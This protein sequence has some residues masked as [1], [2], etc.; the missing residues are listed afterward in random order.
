[1]RP[2]KELQDSS[3]VRRD[4]QSYLCWRKNPWVYCLFYTVLVILFGAV[5][6]IT[7]SG[8]GCGQHWPSCKGDI[9][10]LP[11]SVETVIE[12]T[13]RVTSLTSMLL[14]WGLAIWTYRSG[15]FSLATR[16]SALGASFGMLLEALV[17]AAL[18]LLALVGENDSVYRAVIMGAHLCATS[19][20]LYF[21]VLLVLRTTPLASLKPPLQIKTSIRF[22]GRGGMALLLLISAAGAVTAL[23]DTLYP[24]SETGSGLGL[25][26]GKSQGQHFLESLRAF[27]PV[28][29][30][31]GAFFL[32]WGG[33]RFGA[34]KSLSLG[35]RLLL[36]AQLVA[37]FS[38]IALNA[39]GW[40]QVVH[41]LLAN[42]IWMLWVALY[43]RSGQV[44]SAVKTTA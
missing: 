6:R 11:Q 36:G 8:A 37:G 32:Y 34:D 29:A 28:L 7:G 9:V 20:L 44:P 25:L 31:V 40:M 5:V 42:T 27:H 41:L 26:S 19:L 21:L 14:V 18:V 38:N 35:L 15:R 39:P 43:E 3:F 23:G 13:H 24:V 4:A 10:H 22:L 33:P 1:M 30:I 2:A 17:G 16:R 12:L